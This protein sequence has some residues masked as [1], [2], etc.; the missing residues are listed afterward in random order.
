MS[1][2]KPNSSLQSPKDS[3]R[4]V[5]KDKFIGRPPN[6]TIKY[7]NEFDGVRMARKLLESEG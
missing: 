4:V 6:K 5:G 2:N 1:L 3:S 7:S